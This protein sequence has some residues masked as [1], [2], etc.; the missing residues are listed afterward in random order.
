[1]AGAA[2]SDLAPAYGLS[3][4]GLRHYATMERWV[5]AKQAR[6]SQ[7]LAMAEERAR[8]LASTAKPV[9]IARQLRT[10]ATVDRHVQRLLEGKTLKPKELDQLARAFKSSADVA[11][12]VVGMDGEPTQNLLLQVNIF[13]SRPEPKS[14]EAE[15]GV[16][17][18]LPTPLLETENVRGDEKTNP[19]D[20]HETAL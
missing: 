5:K 8:A 14:V 17:A 10:S 2:L 7:L 6:T 16:L 20:G 3:V 13:G 4:L 11:A 12:R 19:D 18:P 9:V 1:M 15:S